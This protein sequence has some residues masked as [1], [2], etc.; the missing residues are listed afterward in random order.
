MFDS[1]LECVQKLI[2]VIEIERLSPE[3]RDSLEADLAR[4]CSLDGRG[5]GSGEAIERKNRKP[6]KAVKK[7]AG[8]KKGK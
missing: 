1:E 2:E 8:E 6:R 3:S 4:L 7:A 5:F